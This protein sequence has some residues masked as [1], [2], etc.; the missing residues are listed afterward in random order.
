[1]HVISDNLSRSQVSR[2]Q[3]ELV[4][5]QVRHDSVVLH[6]LVISE[7]PVDTTQKLQ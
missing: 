1:M 2:A 7:E 3:L 4:M 5:L 6:L